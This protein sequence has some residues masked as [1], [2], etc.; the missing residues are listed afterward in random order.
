MF[1]V[2]GQDF[3]KIPSKINYCVIHCYTNDL[4]KGL[5]YSKVNLYSIGLYDSMTRQYKVFTP[6]KGNKGFQEY[7][8]SFDLVITF[9]AKFTYNLL[10]EYGYEIRTI[11]SLYNI[12]SDFYQNSCLSLN[13]LGKKFFKIEREMGGGDLAHFITI[14]TSNRKKTKSHENIKKRLFK[15]MLQDIRITHKLYLNLFDL[16]SNA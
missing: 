1:I 11:L 10:R 2:T 6:G 14:L 8:D 15:A 16:L 9:T 3:L 13:S 4:P 12:Y 5:D 7:L